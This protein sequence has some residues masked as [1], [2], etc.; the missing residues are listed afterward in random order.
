MT[1]KKAIKSH[2]AEFESAAGD[3]QKLANRLVERGNA[4]ARDPVA[5]ARVQSMIERARTIEKTVKSATGSLGFAKDVLG[6]I[7]GVDVA[8]SKLFVE[9][10][11]KVLQGVTAAVK[12]FNR[13]CAETIARLEAGTLGSGDVVKIGGILSALA[14][15]GMFYLNNR[16]AIGRTLKRIGVQS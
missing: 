11:D 16:D 4:L 15:G 3:F 14:I 10:S 7:S 13:E 9:S 12:W 8:Q 2:L 5:R 1:A 6:E